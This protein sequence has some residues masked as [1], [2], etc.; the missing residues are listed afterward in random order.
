M[1]KR[2]LTL[3]TAVS[4]AAACASQKA[5][6]DAAIKA[7]QGAFDA[8]RGEAQSLVPDQAKA[9]SDALAGA[10]D[11]FTKGDYQAALTAAQDASG[12]ATALAQAVAA[13]KDELAKSWA[14]MSGSLPGMV[15]AISAKVA[16][17]SKA[18]R[19]PKGMDKET[20]EN[21]KAG[22]EMMQA[23]W[24]EAGAAASAGNVMDA[25]AKAT[26][27]KEK[28]G[29]VMAMLGMPMPEAAPA[30]EAAK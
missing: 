13:K 22:L 29:E 6:A 23:A 16:E 24:G 4:L 7:A 15:E 27:V 10:Q 21:A 14:E 1:I 19:L 3:A 25:V 18:R 5:P 17:L 30:A 11:A 12:K 2:M 20:V 9:V 8:V 28:A 26:T